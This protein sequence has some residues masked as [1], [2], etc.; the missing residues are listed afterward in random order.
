M[1]TLALFA[2]LATAASAAPAPTIALVPVSS[3]P[4]AVGTVV[5]IPRAPQP[6]NGSEL[7][8]KI[9]EDE[10]HYREQAVE[11]RHQFDLRLGEERTDFEATL[12]DRGF[13]EKR[14][15]LKEQRADQAKRRKAFNDEQERK[16]RT[17]EWRYP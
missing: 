16:R 15:L 2:C 8:G 3:Q 14:R 5:V 7:R 10:R 11:S 6:P 13:W 1:N 4:V 12:A 9:K 17:Y